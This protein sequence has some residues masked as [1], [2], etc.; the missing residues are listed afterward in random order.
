MDARSPIPP[1]PRTR[2]SAHIARVL[3]VLL[4]VAAFILL[5]SWQDGAEGVS[6]DALFGGEPAPWTNALPG[7]LL[8]LLLLALTR[9]LLLSAWLALLVQAL[10]YG[11]DALK[12]ANLDNTLTPQDFR[13][14]GQVGGGTDLFARYLPW[15]GPLPF[16]LVVALAT[17]VALA[18]WE[19]PLLRRSPL[20]R[21]PLAAAGLAAL[22]SLGAG[23]APWQTIYD[24]DA[25]QYRPW[26][27]AASNAARAGLFGSLALIRLYAPSDDA[28]LDDPALAKSLLDAQHD[29]IASRMGDTT[30]HPLPD[31]VIVQSESFFDPARLRGI[32]PTQTVPNLR[33][34]QKLG[35]SG[36][37]SVPTFGG[38]TIRTEF[39]VLT[40]LPL[41]YF[42][43]LQY[44]YLG[45]TPAK[46]PGLIE[47]LKRAGYRSVAVHPNSGGFW[48]RRN[49]F[50]RLGFD[51]FITTDG[52]A[53]AHAEHRGYYIADHDFTDVMLSALADD[54]PPQ[55]VFGIS[56]ENHGPYR[57]VPLGPEQKKQR[58]GIAVPAGL[59]KA[60]TRTLQT[61]LLHQ[62]D[63]DTELGRLADTLAKRSRPT[64]LVFYGDHLPG[65]ESGYADGFDDGNAA[66]QQPVPYLLIEPNAPQAPTRENLP[67]WMLPAEILARAGVRDDAW[68]ALL[69]SL[70]PTLQR[71]GWRPDDVLARQLASASALRLHDQLPTP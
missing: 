54:G 17:T 56:I 18:Y 28:V 6:A 49:V 58:D 32:G 41:A 3:A 53:F 50:E 38:G 57:H 23:A 30:R 16:L 66:D 22:L 10:L 67:A 33:R 34:L 63:A 24:A 2:L 19:P 69:Q 15:D 68:F 48:N 36:G 62:R 52:D 46:L 51:R 45:L 7:V 55:L 20:V 42:P 25:L 9:R 35:Q 39:E 47:A 43:Q 64:L 5:T 4:V 70:A 29:A 11:I 8:L 60:G 12:L 21:A 27:T 71:T 59:D 1:S 44:P 65:L 14:I 40:G 37:L 61:Y 26:E 13:L 31:I